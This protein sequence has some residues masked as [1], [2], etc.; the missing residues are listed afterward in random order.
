LSGRPVTIDQLSDARSL[1]ERAVRSNSAG[2]P[3]EAAASLEVALALLDSPSPSIPELDRLRERCNTLITLALSDFLLGGVGPARARLREAKGVADL[4]DDDGLRA[5][6]AFQRATILGRGG[7]LAAAWDEMQQAISSPDAFTPREQCSVQIN[8]GMLAFELSQP[9]LALEAFAEA[10]RVAHAHGFVQQEQ[11][12]RHNAGHALY[13]LGD[14]PRSLAAMAEAGRL[15][16]DVPTARVQL[17][18]ARVMLEAGL[19][20]DALEVLGSA[21]ADLVGAGQ[22][23]VLA[24]VE[25]ERARALRLTGRLEAAASAASAALEACERLGAVGWATK[26]RLMGLL[27]ELARGADA[28]GHDSRA[29]AAQ[30]DEVAERATA[31]GDVQLARSA[32]LVAGEAFLEAGD[33][34]QARARLD[35]LRGSHPGSLS[36]EL[37]TAW[38]TASLHVAAGE[39]SRA[40]RQL[41]SA[42]RR[43]GAAQSGSASLDL[44][45]AR[46]VHGVRLAA[47]DLGLSLP[48]GS[49]GVLQTL[50]R[51]RSATD[52]LA[53]LGRPGDTELAVL[54]EQLRSVHAQLRADPDAS[55]TRDLAR[56]VVSLERQ[57][58]SRDWALSSSSEMGSAVPVRVR[59][60]REA[61]D[62]ADRDLLWFFTRGDRLYALGIV[63]G[64]TSVRD[65]M[66][67][68]EAEELARRI[69]VDLRAA[70]TRHLGP[71]S[72]TVWGSLRASAKRLDDSLVRPWK[73]AR[74][75]L[76]LVTCE[77]LSALPW[78][79]LPSL[80]GRPVTIAR[81]L[82]SFARRERP[83]PR[84]G[85][86]AGAAGTRVRVGVGPGLARGQAEGDAVMATWQASGAAADV[87]RTPRAADLVQALS[88]SG[89]VHVVA[90]GTHQPQSPL[91]S[92]LALD[93]GPV[94]AH[95]LQPR[96]VGADHV[97]L[98]ACEVGKT[99]FRPGEEQLGLAASMLSLGARSVVAAVA[100]VPDDVAAEVMARHHEGLAAGLAGDEALAAAVAA[101]DPVSA[102]FLN[103]GGRWVPGRA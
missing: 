19:V 61:L 4:L 76:V 73:A 103:L 26:A 54:T 2:R 15:D 38:F 39:P 41:S 58:R 31:L 68:G 18:R 82:T 86:G 32:S 37:D 20:S 23:Q 99:S 24:E 27:V 91:F 72:Q 49:S 94:F 3:A 33:L 53:S 40:K 12:A 16:G 95:E 6:V 69:R 71:M 48:T 79:L 75:G 5:R 66:A 80:A 62:A 89:V 42:A 8:R 13:L 96:G 74:A 56:R 70:A 29:I 46:A 50:E 85:D 81:S 92:S 52:R 25:L 14:L 22:D 90:H 83:S 30:A 63:Q 35:R 1:R 43:L 60:G 51:W 57:I 100:P 98:S 47:L 77:E 28:S 45:T 7:D 65:L 88:G 78:A 44:R 84:E 101:S 59:E 21:V 87:A 10:A 64:R 102:A 93:D 97:V 55:T 36:D 17:D 67:R 11:L 9:Q 34:D